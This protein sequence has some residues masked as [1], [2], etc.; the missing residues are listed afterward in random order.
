MR[1]L[2]TVRQSHTIYTIKLTNF[3]WKL[4]VVIETIKKH[5]E[6]HFRE[7]NSI[8]SLSENDSSCVHTCRSSKKYQNA[9]L[10]V[11]T[12]PYSGWQER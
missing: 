9:C 2:I 1:N 3:V 7:S 8:H 11:G 4:H 12:G 10:L 6:K 5:K